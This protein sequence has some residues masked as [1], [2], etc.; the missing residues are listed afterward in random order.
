M[1]AGNTGYALDQA[2]ARLKKA[3]DHESDCGRAQAGTPLGNQLAAAR[4]E[5]SSAETE[6]ARAQSAHDDVMRRR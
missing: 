1:T 5:V 4:R 2:N 3:R 6:A